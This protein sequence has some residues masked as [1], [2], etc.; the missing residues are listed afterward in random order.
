[1]FKKHIPIYLIKYI[2]S[3]YTHLQVHKSLNNKHKTDDPCTNF[4]VSLIFNS[5]KIVCVQ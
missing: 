3:K 1:M 5:V 2:I 4:R